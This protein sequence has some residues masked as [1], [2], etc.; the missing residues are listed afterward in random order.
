MFSIDCNGILLDANDKWFDMTGHSKEKIFSFSWMNVIDDISK[1]AVD[2][3]W[4]DLTVH[5]VPWT[6]ELVCLVQ[7]I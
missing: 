5:H 4:T 6:G 3:S 1:E 2:K 7:S